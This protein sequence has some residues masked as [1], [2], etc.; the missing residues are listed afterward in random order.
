MK[1]ILL[2]VTGSIATY[3]IIDLLRLFE[4]QGHFLSIILSKSAEQFITPLSIKS[5]T[6]ANIYQDSLFENNQDAMLHIN[7]A[8]THDLI[9]IAP[10]SANFIAKIACGFADNFSC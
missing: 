4:K 3:K 1:K 2:I 5:L 6:K 8:R 9:L 7:L 10:A